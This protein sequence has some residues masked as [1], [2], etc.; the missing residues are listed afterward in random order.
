MYNKLLDWVRWLV[1]T[2]NIDGL[3]VDT[4]PMVS[5]N[6]WTDFSKAAGVYT[7]GEVFCWQNDYVAGY[8]GPL[9]ATLNYPIYYSLRNVF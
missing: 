2:Y 9:D 3:R 7:V 5:K 8:Q 6:F 1:T 4:Y